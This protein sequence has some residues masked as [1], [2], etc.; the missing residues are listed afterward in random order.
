M[1]R[2]LALARRAA[3]R[4]APNPMVGCVIVKGGRVVAEGFHRKAGTAHAEVAALAKI[5]P[6]KARGATVYVTLEPCNH[7]G[8]TG[9]CSEALVAAGVGRVVAAMGDPNPH[10]AG[11]GARRLRRAGIPVE[12]GLCEDE[13]RRLNAGFLKHGRTGRPLVT[14][15]AAV[16]LDGRIAAGSG[17]ARW[18]TGEAARREVHRMR[19]RADAILV[20]AGTVIADDPSL[21]TRLPG[22]RG[23]DPLRVIVDGKAGIPPT[24]K[25]VGPGTLIVTRGARGARTAALVAR[26]AE[27]L[28]M[29]GPGGRV[30]LGALLDELGR[31]GVLELLVEGGARIHGALLAA[32]LV[33]RVVVFVAPKIVGAGGVPMVGA[34]GARTMAEAWTLADVRVRRLGDDV[35]IEGDV[36]APVPR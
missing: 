30:D 35:M 6:G 24:A 29:P 9:P 36:A 25:V 26:G 18:V 10:V 32:G 7:T 22:G 28:P 1:R 5:A 11:G 4:T 34:P 3:G 33:D 19:D 21:T 13:A 14:L 8:R 20:G 17:D 15:K 16:S 31:R 12:I 27:V 23:R 2:A